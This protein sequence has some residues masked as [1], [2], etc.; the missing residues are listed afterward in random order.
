MESTPYQVELEVFSGP[1]DL[2]L[3]LI[4]QQQLDITT[5]SLARVTDQYLAYLR[6]I[7]DR[8]PD[9]LADFVSIAARLLL[10]KSRALLPQP[11]TARDEPEEDVG[12]DLVR[13]LREYQRF[14]GIADTLRE[15]DEDGLHTYLRTLPTSKIVNLTPKLDLEGTSLDDLIQA[16]RNLLNEEAEESDELDVVPYRVTI[17]QE[18]ERI[19]DLLRA[20]PATTF[21][22]LI[23]DE[24]SRLEVIV[25]LLALLEMIR[26]QRVSVRQDG[27]FGPVTIVQIQNRDP[28]LPG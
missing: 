15:R 5:I 21:A 8:R 9:E 16:L 23:Q 10:I 19:A 27:L 2:L 18:I 20:R 1:L 17:G 14:K 22:E 25:T 28:G 7:E 3:H 4:E 12:E 11:E 26:A 24:F 13:Q 6:V